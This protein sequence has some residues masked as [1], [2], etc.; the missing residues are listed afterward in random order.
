MGLRIG[1]IAGAGRFALQAIERAKARGYVCVVAGIRGEALPELKIAADVFEWIGPTE[2]EK[3]ITFFKSQGVTETVFVG[4]VEPRTLVRRDGFDEGMSRLLSQV[5]DKTPTTILRTL[6]EVL[7]ARGIRVKDPSFLLEPFLCPSGRL[8]AAAP[9]ASIEEDAAFGWALARSV[10][11]LDIGQTIVVKDKA[12]VAVEGM[13]GTDETI[14]RAGLLAGP[15]IVALKVGRTRQDMRIDVPAVGLET[16]RALVAVHGA[17]LV[18][19]A[20]RVPF[21]QKEE[22]LALADANGI[23]VLARE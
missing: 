2:L 6:I 5:K 23:A 4:K 10:A 16:M 15:G 19:E 18:F 3:L 20:G 17:A 22:A 7:T 11:D 14:R 21:F 13:E 12:I 1:I 9:P 8:S